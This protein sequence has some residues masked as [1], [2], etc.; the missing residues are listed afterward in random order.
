VQLTPLYRLTVYAPYSVDPSEATVLT[1]IGTAAHADQF[2]VT[3]AQNVAGAKPYLNFPRGKQSSFDPAT[4]KAT[5]GR[6]TLRLLD[7]RVTAGGS[8]AIRW[9]T[10]FF[11]DTSGKQR[12]LRCKLK[13]E[14][15]LD[16]TVGS[17]ATMFT[18][19]IYGLTLDSGIWVD[20]E[21]RDVR[22]EVNQRRLFTAAP[23]PA[24][25]YASLPTA[26]PPGGVQDWGGFPA[27][28]GL[29]GTTSI[30]STYT[31][32]KGGTIS[33][34][35]VAVDTTEPFQR[36]VITKDIIGLARTG[37]EHEA[38][39]PN[40]RVTLTRLDTLAS[41]TFRVSPAA[42]GSDGLDAFDWISTNINTPM[43]AHPIIR[44]VLLES[45]D[46][47]ESGYMAF[48]PNGTPVRWAISVVH[49]IDER[50]PLLIADVH[51]AQFWQDILD[52][53][54]SSK[55]SDGT[56]RPICAYD[57]AAFATLIADQTIPK[58][59][60]Y[61]K[62]VADNAIKWIEQYICLPRN[63][64]YRFDP[65]GR[66]VPIDMRR[67]KDTAT[68]IPTI[69]EDDL[70]ADTEPTW[71]IARDSAITGVE[72]TYYIDN[73]LSPS[74][75]V[76]AGDAFPDIGPIQLDETA[77]LV[78]VA[79]DLTTLTD[80]GEKI[81]KIDSV[82]DRV[83]G[84]L[85]RNQQNSG[86]ATDADTGQ[87]EALSTALQVEGML[88]DYMSTFVAGSAKVSLRC[89]RTTSPSSLYPG[90]R[91]LLAVAKLP[92]TLT[93]QRGGTRLMLCI[94]RTEDGPAINLD[95]VD[96][97]SNVVSSVPTLSS[98]A[99]PADDAQA[100]DVQVTVNA[101][102]DPIHLWYAVTASGTGTAPATS[103]PLWVFGG[104]RTTTGLIRLRPLPKNARIFLR[105]QSRSTGATPKLPSDWAYL[106]G[107]AN[108]SR[109]DLGT[110]TAPSAVSVGFITGN[111]A[112]VSWT[113][114]DASLVTDVYLTTGGVPGTWTETMRLQ[115]P[116]P[117]GS[118]SMFV[119]GLTPSSNYAV[120]VR[121]RD[122]TTGATSSF[123]TATFSTTGTRSRALQP[124]QPSIG[125]G[126]SAGT[127]T[128]PAPII[129]KPKNF[130]AS[131]VGVTLNLYPNDPS[132]L[133]EIQHAPDSAGA[134]NVGAAATIAQNVP[135]TQQA[136][137]HQQPIDGATHWYRV[138]HMGY[139][140]TPS[141]WTDW[142]SGQ[143]VVQPFESPTKS[144]A[145]PLNSQSRFR[146]KLFN[147]TLQ[148]IPSGALTPVNFDNEEY[149]V[150]TLHDNAVS[151]SRITIPGGWCAGRL[152]IRG[153]GL[154][155]R[156]RDRASATRLPKERRRCAPRLRPARVIGW[157]VRV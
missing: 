137:L 73:Q 42:K 134:P 39:L 115:P 149:D 24:V 106:G 150:G 17:L 75:L 41:G 131:F 101:A 63:L 129:A 91:A 26:L 21:V 66:M 110:I 35:R 120:A 51:L 133:F 96:E 152:E 37:S 138:R 86:T 43:G 116:L 5:T 12:L 61:V 11:G 28:L 8:N 123:A 85:L 114:G 148:S 112:K 34:G 64:A 77:A 50:A 104:M 83:N 128:S 62:K 49:P 33:S 125:G 10:A 27:V 102:G 65:S 118:S 57:S 78:F 38:A 127:G 157:H 145:T 107:T 25:S 3:S 1:P 36:V 60:Y 44:S 124:P 111:R 136:F 92:D 113:V 146:T 9:V 141:A 80:V 94:S 154:L 20:L 31:G 4:R 74:T 135:G 59:R 144:V 119:N 56:L 121:H 140:D 126:G 89:R 18:G 81:I 23:D 19:R 122:P 99:V 47:S 76:N 90:M 88:R 155:D 7:S 132:Y 58:G 143:A 79:A 156:Q 16:G 103:S 95:F 14:E 105:A 84:P 87:P 2:I 109:V 98:A 53:K 97:G 108:G 40:A 55:N 32:P 45:L 22:E 93:N 69:G 68:G 139:G 130:S 52:G 46:P 15:S 30:L 29:L 117:P 147:S 151:N 70:F 153:A 54:F 71:S 67:T 6:L 13:L 82:G 100:L 142:V 48:P 72:F